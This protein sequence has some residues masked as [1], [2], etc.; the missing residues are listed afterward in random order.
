MRYRYDNQAYVS[1][2]QQAQAQKNSG[3]SNL[4]QGLNEGAQ[5]LP[6]SGLLKKEQGVSQPQGNIEKQPQVDD[7]TGALDD[8]ISGGST[9]QVTH[10]DPNLNNAGM[11]MLGNA[12]YRTPETIQA[13][14]E[15]AKQF[16][17]FQDYT[18]GVWDDKTEAV[19]NMTMGLDP[20]N[21]M[22]KRFQ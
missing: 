1:G 6:F 21:A 8:L 7:T 10:R 13:F 9:S 2:M 16:G 18:P 11:A 17:G 15:D 5:A 22:L 12:A 19:Y 14:Q 4:F 3:F 20:T